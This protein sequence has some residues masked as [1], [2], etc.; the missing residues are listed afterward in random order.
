MRRRSGLFFLLIASL[1]LMGCPRKT[2]IHNPRIAPASAV[3][4]QSWAE[5]RQQLDHVFADPNF[6][7]AQWGVMIQSLDTGEIVYQR[8]AEKLFMPASNMKLPTGI[9]A[10][11]RLGGDYVFHTRLM[12][13]GPVENGVLKGD[14]LVEGS[15]DPTLSARFNEE[16]PLRQFRQWAGRLKSAGVQRIEGRLIGD[17]DAFE[18]VSLG[19]GWAWNYLSSG[20][21]A[22]IGALQFNENVLELRLQ[23]GQAAGDPVV[24]QM[25]PATRFAELIN[26]AVTAAKESESDVNVERAP[27]SNQIIVGGQIPAASKEIARLVA[28]SNPT[29]YF[30][31]VFKEVLESEGI[32]V[33]GRPVDIDTLTPKPLKTNTAILFE[34]S[35]PKLSE[36]LKVML[37]E[38]QNLFAE[39]LVKTLGH[40]LRGQGSFAAGREVVLEVLEGFAVPRDSWVMADGSGLSRN[41]YIA[42]EQMVRL[43]RGISRRKEFP[44]FLECLP[45]AG[46]DGTLRSRFKGT[47]AENNVRAKTG[48]IANVRTLSGFVRTADGEML[49]F[50]MQANHFTV[51]SRL[52]E[53][54]QDLALEILANF[55]RSK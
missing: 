16:D 15:G 2:D 55:T 23:A 22:E 44:V 19:A 3:T 12:A 30:V 52:A 40:E 37:K 31:E 49:V 53:Y 35:S 51:A 21:A 43:L 46:V 1:G 4:S 33:A 17:D 48:S 6:L 41:N 10:L 9:S 18:D 20:Y 39:T 8:N 27:L 28:I 50:S 34:H 26:R 24:I 5:V 36:I 45:L 47:R 11:L 14:L 32:P 54:D 38:S 7:N 13:L 25:R 29:Q 42:P